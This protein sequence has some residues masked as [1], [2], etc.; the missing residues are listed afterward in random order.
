MDYAIGDVHG[1]YDQ[2][3]HLLDH[4]SFDEK[5]DRL[6][7]V[8]DLVNR[9]PNALGVLRFLSTLSNQPNITLGN[10]DLHFLAVYFKVKKKHPQKD[11]FS[12]LVTASDIDV[13]AHW[14]RRQPL[15]VYDPELNVLMVHAGV[16]PLWTLSQTLTHALEVAQALASEENEVARF[17]SFMYGNEPS[18]WSL[19]L[20]GVDKLRCVV[21]YFTRMR[22]VDKKGGLLLQ[23][24]TLAQDENAYPWFERIDR[25]KLPAELVFGHWASLNGK[26]QV[27]GVYGLDTGCVYGGQLSALCLQTKQRYQVPGY[28]A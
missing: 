17:L 24:K 13:L 20:V 3:M 25:A 9:G 11:N 8:G 6:W 10:H 22:Y 14:L 27:P 15:V 4:I 1:C 7:L 23:Y 26:V 21:N 12:Q 18:R 5:H 16:C 19:D 2:L 28:Q